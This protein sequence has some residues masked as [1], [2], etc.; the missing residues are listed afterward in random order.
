MKYIE[1]ATPAWSFGTRNQEFYHINKK[2]NIGKSNPGPGTY[3][4][5]K[6]S[7]HVLSNGPKWRIGTE[8]RQVNNLK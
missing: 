8:K 7:Q 6:S 3:N 2:A 5:N 1:N 4:I